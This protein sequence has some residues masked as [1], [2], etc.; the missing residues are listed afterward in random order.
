MTGKNRITVQFDKTSIPGILFGVILF[1]VLSFGYAS[2]LAGSI[3][4]LAFAAVSFLR[5]ELSDKRAVLTLYGIWTAFCIAFLILFPYYEIYQERLWGVM[6]IYTKPSSFLI[7]TVLILAGMCLFYAVTAKWRLSVVLLSAVFSALIIVNGYV[8]RLRGKEFLFSDVFSANTAFNVAG[9]YSLA[10]EEYTVRA[11]ALG[12]LILFAGFCLPVLPGKKDFRKR[13]TALALSILLT[14][15]FGICTKNKK[16]ITWNSD[17]TLMYGYYTNLYISCRDYFVEKPEGY[18][19]D[20]ITVLEGEY[21]SEGRE[22]TGK[23]PNILIVMNES[24]ADLRI[25]GETPRT[26]QPVTPFLDSLQEN[27]ISGY[28]LTSVY[29]GGTA[30]AEFE[31]LTG[32]SMEFFPEN[33]TPYQQYIHSET[34]ALPWVLKELGYD[35]AATHPYLANGWSRPKVYPLFGF[36]ESTF[37]E[38]Y[39]QKNL[40]RDYVSDREM[41][42][43]MLQQLNAAEEAP[44]FLF[45]ITMQNHGG[46]AM[47]PDSFTQRIVLEDYSREYPQTEEYLSLMYESDIALEYLITELEKQ[48]EETVLLFFGDHLPQIEPE[49]YEELYGGTFETLDSQLLKYTVPFF[50]WANYDIPEQRVECT[51]LNYLGRYLLEAAG[52]ELPPYFRFLK[53]A[54]ENIPAISAMGYYSREKQRFI[55]T[56]EAAG[57][58]KAWLQRYEI[59]QYNGLF[60]RDNRSDVFFGISQK[61]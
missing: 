48:P 37:I 59:L 18:S 28:A 50:L 5:L 57:E 1:A 38:G 47:Y 46:Y 25:F 14:A 42:E 33:S 3:G 10:M 49:F 32:L 60:D 6:K 30:N 31:C 22:P 36:E 53:E 24:F 44:L 19:P 11:L 9:Q 51:S 39:P 17:G 20:S 2:P 54:E 55:P 34:L 23:H 45:G 16:L 7:T 58:E 13:L 8:Y 43:H 12:I 61:D 26:N 35:C 52:L 27:M 40:I 4:F 21:A 29:G 56:E 15:T 41:Y